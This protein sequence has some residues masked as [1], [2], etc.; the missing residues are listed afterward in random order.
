M[1]VCLPPSLR[2]SLSLRLDMPTAR[3][4]A[5][6]DTFQTRQQLLVSAPK[7]LMLIQAAMATMFDLRIGR[8]RKKKNPTRLSIFSLSL[9]PLADRLCEHSH[10]W[11][12]FPSLLHC[13]ASQPIPAFTACFYIVKPAADPRPAGTSALSPREVT[14]VS[15]SS[16]KKKKQ[17]VTFEPTCKSFL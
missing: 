5:N 4:T 15:Q 16:L 12:F 6:T 9:P 7:A 2:L 13:S 17:T 11:P 8:R 3:W 10:S 14:E 1:F